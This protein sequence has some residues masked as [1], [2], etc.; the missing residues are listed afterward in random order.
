MGG[1]LEVYIANHDDVDS[2]TIADG[3]VKAITMVSATPAPK[4]K[5]YL[6]NPQTGSMTSTYNIDAANNVNFVST[7]LVLQFG[8]MET[9][10]RIEISALA[11][12][13]L[14]VIV[15]DANGTYFYLGKDNPVRATAGDGQTGTARTDGNRYSIT[16]QDNSPEMP[17]EVL[18]GAGGV[19]L[20]TIVE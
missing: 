19:D 4:F 8:K 7:D 3:M 17:Y 20:S 13:D 14:A 5:K 16:L 9:T 10:K 1:I 2:L 11:L 12:A 6:F 18:V 15:K